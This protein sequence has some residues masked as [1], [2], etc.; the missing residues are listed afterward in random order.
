MLKSRIPGSLGITLRSK[1]TK[2]KTKSLYGP[3][4]KGDPFLSIIVG[5]VLVDRSI[6]NFSQFE[7]R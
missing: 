6:A 1:K 7:S 3:E 5:T 2:K 4:I